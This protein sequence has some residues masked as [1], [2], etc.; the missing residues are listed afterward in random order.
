MFNIKVEKECGCF[1]KS[2]I[3][4]NQRVDNKDDALFKAQNM[5]KE[6]NE[7]FCQKHNFKVVESDNDFIIKVEENKASTCCG[8]GHCH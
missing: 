3:Q 6:M 4:N 5:A 8:G 7:T 2:S 1:K